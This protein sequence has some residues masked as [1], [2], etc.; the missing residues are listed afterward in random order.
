MRCLERGNAP[1]AH[2]PCRRQQRSRDDRQGVAAIECFLPGGG[3]ASA[4][5]SRPYTLALND[6][7]R[8]LTLVWRA[9]STVPLLLD[10]RSMHAQC[11]PAQL[12]HHGLQHS[13]KR[14]LRIGRS[15]SPADYAVQ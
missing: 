13:F 6:V 14:G 12:V 1:C 10:E 9:P 4:A 3:A 5:V 2:S 11:G 15:L 7:S 8:E